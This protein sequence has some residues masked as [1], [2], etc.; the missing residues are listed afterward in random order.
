MWPGPSIIT[1]TSCSQAIFVS[2]P[3]VSSSPN[4]AASLASARQPGP[5]AVA[6]REGDV[7]GL[8][9]LADL[10][11]P[12]IQEVLAVMRQAPLRHDR[13]SARDDAGD[14]AGGQ[15]HVSQAHAGVDGEIVHTLFGLLDQRVAEQLP[16]EFLGPAVD[17]FQRLVDRHR[18]DRHRAVAQDPLAGLVDVPARR[19][20]HQRVAAPAARPDQL[21]HLLLDAGGDGRIADVGVDLHPEVAA[22]DHRFQFRMV[23]VRGDD[24]AAGRDFVAHELGGDRLGNAG[25]ERLAGMLA[26]QLRVAG[27]GAHLLQAIVLADRDELHLRGHDAAAGVVHLADVGAGLGAARRADV[28]EAQAG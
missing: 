3:S 26:Q 6:Q 24:R 5:Q 13:S 15:R 11:E 16:G 21:L 4:W 12:G 23:D 8:H 1:C 9:D 2:S 17:L 19:Q 10:G 25:A 14:P 20:V 28:R 18:A 27:I 7:V 22:D